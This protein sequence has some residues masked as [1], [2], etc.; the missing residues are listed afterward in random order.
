LQRDGN[1]MSKG[2]LERRRARAESTN[3]VK[4]DPARTEKRSWSRADTIATASA[5]AAIVAAVAAWWGTW[6]SNR[7]AEIHADFPSIG[8]Y[9][10]KYLDWYVYVPAIFTNGHPDGNR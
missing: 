3:S 1:A 5:L 8:L 2:G 10:A 4:F 7:P 6:F 9:E